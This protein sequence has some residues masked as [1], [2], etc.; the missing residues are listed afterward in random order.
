MKKFALT[1]LAITTISQSALA[2][3]RF[4]GGYGDNGW[5][6]FVDVD[7]VPTKTYKVNSGHLANPDF[8]IYASTQKRLGVTAPT[9]IDNPSAM[10]GTALTSAKKNF[11]EAVTQ[12]RTTKQDMIRQIKAIAPQYGVDPAAVLGA[13]IAEL[14]FNNYWEAAFQNVAAQYLPA[15]MNFPRVATVEAMLQHRA[16]KDCQPE[17][18]DYWSWVCINNVWSKSIQY[19]GQPVNPFLYAPFERKDAMWLREYLKPN[20]GISYGPAQ[21]SLAVSLIVMADVNKV[22]KGAIKHYKL[23]DMSNIMKL[24][25]DTNATIHIVSAIMARAEQVYNRFAFLDISKNIGVQVTLFNL[26]DESLRAIKMHKV[27]KEKV[28]MDQM[29]ILPRENYLGWFV[30]ENEAVIR[31][32]L[33]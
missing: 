28:S 31:Q 9:L 30:N 7:A 24:V 25:L 11:I 23:A 14:T 17:R 4:I 12:I 6:I 19:A 1:L 32:L 10:T 33:K 16:F 21:L 5:K 18:S 3:K 27:N 20:T 22:T 26:G 15:A 2:E 13:I 29:P 8:K